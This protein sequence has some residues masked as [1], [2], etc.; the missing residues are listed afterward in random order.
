MKLIAL[1]QALLLYMVGDIMQY[2]TNSRSGCLL[3][4]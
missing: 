1:H 4:T 2:K 3:R